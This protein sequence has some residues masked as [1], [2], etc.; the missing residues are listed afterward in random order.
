ME[1]D[2]QIRGD[3]GDPYDFDTHCCFRAN[4]TSLAIRTTI[5]LAQANEW[6]ERRTNAEN[7]LFTAGT[8]RTARGPAARTQR[9]PCE[10]GGHGR[11]CLAERLTDV[12]SRLEGAMQG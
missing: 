10:R 9:V 6:G 2:F 11:G 8:I 1:G 7:V 3:I 4:G 5:L 12:Y